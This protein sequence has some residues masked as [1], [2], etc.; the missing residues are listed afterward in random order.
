M[1]ESERGREG[2]IKC[3]RE[4]IAYVEGRV[5]S[6]GWDCEKKGMKICKEQKMIKRSIYL[7]KYKSNEQFERR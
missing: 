4:E 7:S 2:M 1:V 5:G 6:N 3:L